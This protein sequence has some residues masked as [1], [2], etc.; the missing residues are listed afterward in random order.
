[1]S[2]KLFMKM[3]TV[4][5]IAL[6]IACAGVLTLAPHR[7]AAADTKSAGPKI[8]YYT[9]PMHPS[10]KADKPGNCPIC[11][12]TLRPVYEKTTGTNAPPAAVSTNNPPATMP[13]CSMGSGCCN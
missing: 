8:L 6:V 13:G 4:L 9:C 7:V 5:L 12:M 2:E 1:M 11:G 3:K 10:V